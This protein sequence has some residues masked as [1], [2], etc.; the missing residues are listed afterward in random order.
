MEIVLGL[1]ITGTTARVVLVEGQRA[2]GVT[3]E[4]EVFDT[5]APEGVPMPSPT[6]QVSNAILAT[7]QNALANGHHLVVSGVTWDGPTQ[8]AELRESMIARGLDDAVLVPEQ[9]AAGALAQTIGRALGYE[10][11]AVLVIKLDTATL[12]IVNCADGSI[13]EGLPHNFC[14]ANV[15]DVIPEI[16]ASLET[17]DP[18]L[19]GI[20]IVGSRVETGVVKSRLESLLAVPVIAPEEPELGLARGAALA[21]ASAV[22]LEAPTAGLAYSQDPDANEVKL[23]AADTVVSPPLEVDLED[24]D[25]LDSMV[26][27]MERAALIP[28][29]S[30]VAAVCV[31]GVVALMMS[32]AFSSGGTTAQNQGLREA[33]K[34]A[35]PSVVVSTPPPAQDPAAVRSPVSVPQAQVL[36]PPPSSAI[37][38]PIQVAADPP[39]AAPVITPAPKPAARAP[40]TKQPAPQPAPSRLITEPSPVAAEAPYTE[41]PIAVQPPPAEAQPIVAPAAALPP[42]AVPP[43]PVAVPPPVAAAPFLPPSQTPGLTFPSGPPILRIGPFRIPLGPTQPAAQLPQQQAPQSPAWSPPQAPAWSPPQ[44]P[45]WSPPRHRPGHRPGTGLVTAPGTGLVTA[46]GTGLVTAPGTGLVTAP[47]TGLVT[48]PGTGLVTA[49]RRRP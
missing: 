14:G 24:D 30:L 6:E 43:P 29:G 11:T 44:A 8:Q 9:S 4:S 22:G 20:V 41:A 32:L 2:D 39:V 42:V 46:P 26:A 25:D 21:A 36:Q 3:I 15:A 18:Q 34:A 1:S 5:A 40:V 19:Q 7:Q 38:E 28:I 12:S 23:S 45:A 49:R 31:L 10:T 27:R 33:E 13:V 37:P 35:A 17:I 48:A 16:M 47:G